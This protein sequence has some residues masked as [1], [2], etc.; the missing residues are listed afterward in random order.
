MKK[1]VKQNQK[2]I[3]KNYSKYYGEMGD[4]EA[5]TAQEI[6]ITPKGPGSKGTPLDAAPE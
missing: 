2:N 6:R 4:D 5:S 1:K 3:N